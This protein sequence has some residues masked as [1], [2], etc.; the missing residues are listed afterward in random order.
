MAHLIEKFL[1]AQVVEKL[2]EVFAE[3]KE[4]VRIL[5]FR[6]QDGCETCDATQQLLQEV[7]AVSDK[8][9]LDVLDLAT[10]QALAEQFHV[11]KTPS[12]VITAEKGVE[13]VDLGIRFVGIPSGHEF[14]T[15]ITDILLVSRR[16]SGLG[17]KARDYLKSL[18][19]PLLLQVFV[20]PT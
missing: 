11:D 6:S 19:Q 2:R 9:Q 1:D 18:S 13:I 4:P 3:L 15:L 12:L 5:L 10:D 8:V 16:D 20:T 14:N 17:E 7:T